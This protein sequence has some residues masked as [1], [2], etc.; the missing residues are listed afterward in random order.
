MA[1]TCS[2]LSCCCLSLEKEDTSTVAQ[3]EDNRMVQQHA[4][5]KKDD[6][7]AAGY[8]PSLS[9]SIFSDYWK[10]QGHEAGT[11]PFQFLPST[12]T[13]VPRE[14]VGVPPRSPDQP[15]ASSCSGSQRPARRSIF[16]GFAQA[17]TTT[18]TSPRALAASS[19]YYQRQPLPQPVTTTQSL[20]SLLY[21]NYYSILAASLA[22]R[23][24]QSHS[25]LQ[26]PRPSVL[27]RNG[28]FGSYSG[29]GGVTANK[30]LSSIQNQT[31]TIT[32]YEGQSPRRPS[33]SFQAQVQVTVVPAASS[34]LLWT[35]G[36]ASE[37]WSHW[38]A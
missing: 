12:P 38:F 8:S 27:R 14:Q 21:S 31:T 22:T 19:P 35:D 26:Q 5:E 18:T 33:V 36:W 37:D 7:T 17:T 23:K 2:S 16:G 6:T 25:A 10:A 4:P 15:D 11:C 32:A 1:S 29:G 34:G 24:T 28:R 3:P 9:R 20:P 13:F 30:A